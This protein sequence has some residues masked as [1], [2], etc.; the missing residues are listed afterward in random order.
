LNAFGK[1]FF[2]NGFRWPGGDD[3]YI[4]EEPVSLGAD[5]NKK[6][7][8]DAIWPSDIPGTAPISIF[9]TGNITYDATSDIKWGF[10]FPNYLNILYAG[11]LGENFSIFGE[12]E[13][14]NNNNST[15]LSFAAFIQWDH[16]PGLHVKLGEVRAD[17]TP[18]D[19]KITTNDYNIETLTSRNGW[20]FG[21]PEFG[22]ELWGAVN[23]FGNRGG[24]TY[25]VGV[26]NG[27]GLISTKPQ[28]DFC[29]KFTFKLGGLSETGVTK[30]VKTTATKP[31]VDNSITVGGFFYKGTEALQNANDENLTVFGGDAELWFDRFILSSSAMWMNSEIMDTTNRK[32]M[33][34]YVQGSGLVYPWLI[35][36]VRYEWTN[37]D[38]NNTD[39]KPVTSIIPG[40]SVLVRANLKL[41]FEAQK[42]FDEINKKTTTFSMKVSI[43]L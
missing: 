42:Y 25:R 34:Y 28:K 21:D 7:W 33:A 3:K 30:N 22:L 29:G 23:G 8:P 10:G 14:S 38:I 24:L 43:G 37:T 40:I 12:T 1:A 35:G 26:V 27:Q 32:S 36:H 5:G 39:V 18:R 16:S 19:L 11:T 2:N 15:D 20:S 41:T 13:L 31:Y 17:P 9:A 6:A 4:K